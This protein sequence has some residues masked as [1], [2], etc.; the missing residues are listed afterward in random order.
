LQNNVAGRIP[1][2]LVFAMAWFPPRVGGES[3]IL[4]NMAKYYPQERL[5]YVAQHVTGAKS[6]DKIFPCTVYRVKFSASRL[7]IS[8]FGRLAKTIQLAS[9]VWRER[10]NVVLVGN[11][12]VSFRARNALRAVPRKV[13]YVILVHG[14]ELIGIEANERTIRPYLESA[15]IIANSCYT[16]NLAVDLGIPSSHIDVIRPGCDV[17]M[18]RPGLT[19]GDWKRRLK[20]DDKKILLTVGAL[21]ERKGQDMVIRALRYVKKQI[22][23][24]HYLIVGAGVYEKTLKTIVA[25]ENVDSDVTFLGRIADEDLPYLY[26]M[27]D[28]FV[29]PSREASGTVEGLGMVFAEAGSCGKPCIAG[30]SGGMG[31]IVMDEKTGVLVDPQS[32]EDI[33]RG[34][35]EILSD[36]RKA[37]SMG[38]EGRKNVEQCYSNSSYYEKLLRTLLEYSR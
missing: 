20:L 1:K 37:L 23:R 27:C 9:I 25:Q 24:I 21:V 26:N 16:K 11:G 28:V 5:V 31:E 34:I 33:A 17:Q 4:R 30:L 32:V 15:K 13:P 12:S 29:M 14:T 2:I 6:F 35:I 19:V 8:L 3:N 36:D 7:G 10:P 22:P 18:F 38:A